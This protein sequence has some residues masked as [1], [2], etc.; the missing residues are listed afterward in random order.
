MAT[1]RQ[2]RINTLLFEQLSLLVP[3]EASEDPRLTN[4]TVTKV[5]STQDLATAKVFFIADGDDAETA[6][7]L[8]AL[9]ASEGVLRS[10]LANLGLR[11]LPRLVFARDR[12]Y[13]SGERVLG[14]LEQLRAEQGLELSPEHDEALETGRDLESS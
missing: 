7:A 13:E 5:E 2:Q 8:E 11:R 9:K 4:V 6:E 10:E 12:D 1:R 3:A 14:I